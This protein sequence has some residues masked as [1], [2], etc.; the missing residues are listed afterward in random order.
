MTMKTKSHRHTQHLG[1]MTSTFFLWFRETAI[2]IL[3]FLNVCFE[4]SSNI[5][6]IYSHGKNTTVQYTEEESKN[7]VLSA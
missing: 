4:N 3:S 2:P 5:L 6:W 1:R 7:I